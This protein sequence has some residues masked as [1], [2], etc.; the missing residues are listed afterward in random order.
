VGG[1]CA[2]PPKNTFQQLRLYFMK[3]NWCP[4]CILAAAMSWQSAMAGSLED[5][6][7]NPPESARAMTFWHWM[8]GLVGK[9]GITAD[10]ES[11]KRAG[12]GGVLIY[13]IG[14]RTRVQG[15]VEY[16]SGEWFD[17]M[18]FAAE[19]AKRIGLEFSFH[20]CPGWSSSGGPW[21][22]P[23][24]SMQQVV[25]TEI[26]VAG[27]RAFE[28]R[29]PQPKALHDFYR[30]IAVLALPAT[31]TVRRNQIVDVTPQM[32]SDGQLTWKAPPGKW[33]VLRFGHTST[34]KKVHPTPAGGEGLECDKMN[35]AAVDLHFKSYAGRIL[36]NSRGLVG[37]TIKYVEIDSYE[38]GPQNWTQG[39]REIFQKQNGYD[40]IPWLP[41]L[42]GRTVASKTLSERF[43]WD[44]RETVGRAVER[45]YFGGFARNVHSYP[46]LKF[47]SEPYGTE[48]PFD[49]CAAARHG[50]LL[51]GEF[52][53][54]NTDTRGWRKWLS[55][56]TSTS[57]VLGKTVVGAEAFTGEPWVTRWS[58]DPYAL[59]P[60]GDYAFAEGI[61]LFALHCTVHQPWKNAVPPG[62]IMQFWGTHFGRT[63]T[64]WEISRPWFDYLARCQYLLRQGRP[65]VDILKLGETDEPVPS[66][67]KR[68]TCSADAVLHDLQVKDGVLTLPHGQTYRVLVL[69]DD[70]TMTPELAARVRDLI[71]AGAHVLGPKPLASPSFVNFP[72]C[73][74]RVQEIAAELWDGNKI[75]PA[76]NIGAFLAANGIMPDFASSSGNMAWTHR[77]DGETDIY[78]LSNQLPGERVVECDFRVTGK[79]PEL[80]DAA[81]GSHRVAAVYAIGKSTTTLS[82]KFDPAGSV[83][84]I[85]RKPAES[86]ATGGT[87]WTQYKKVQEIPGSWTATF[88]PAWGGPGKVKFPKLGDWTKRTE[89]GIRYYSGTAVYET[90]FD[91]TNTSTGKNGTVLDLGRVKNLAQVELNGKD[92]GILWKPP[93]RVPVGGL[94]KPKSNRLVV[95][96][97]NLWPNRMIGDE[98]E[99][100]D[101]QWGK[102]V[103]MKWHGDHDAGRPLLELPD[104]L[105][106][107]KP[108]PSKGRF[109]FTTWNYYDKD[110]PLLESG[111]LGP[112]ELLVSP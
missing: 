51:L 100:P 10:L 49:T 21:I 45:N 4:A 109:T 43:E 101:L 92:L 80:W 29:L 58:E 75:R 23:E 67:Y 97:T 46:G 50:D 27:G 34:G 14:G 19:E 33:V 111:L 105:A 93:F 28:G 17:L 55:K 57:T 54:G 91:L 26:Q 1:W 39:F 61:N 60:G 38:A 64:W 86:S 25:W 6:F 89:P 68:N 82:L 69:A 52:W 7:K 62:I 30:D 87:N 9:E 20:N 104:W 76:D 22:T 63:Q 18:K 94:L 35:S 73:D 36:E 48:E 99:P 90:T 11:M 3:S 5:D 42:A 84:V 31:G 83:F 37:D 85:F 79:I 108:R 102:N 65:V 107:G 13:H 77:R 112:V 15:D 72:E 96:I 53:H 24:L 78:F 88:D 103:M 32:T 74:K 98:Q 71:N 40:I 16:M 95:R 41:V 8:N 66:G 106:Q 2:G 81:D 47:A 59:K 12:L 110:S 70:T 56:M 44:L